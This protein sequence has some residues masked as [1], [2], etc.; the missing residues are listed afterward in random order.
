MREVREEG[1]GGGGEGVRA[2]AG[3]LA[4]RETYKGTGTAR[5]VSE[6]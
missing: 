2:H 3:V 1:G 4:P 5:R 6:A